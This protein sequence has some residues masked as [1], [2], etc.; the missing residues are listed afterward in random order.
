[1][2]S[3]TALKETGGGEPSRSVSNLALRT[4]TAL[5]G[6]PILVA[7]IWWGE[8]GVFLLVSAF[9]ILGVRE[10]YGLPSLTPR[11]EACGGGA[12]RSAG[13]WPAGRLPSLTPRN[14]ACGGGASRSPGSWPAGRLAPNDATKL[15]ALLGV[16][17]AFA[18]VVAA[19][20]T[21]A[22]WE[23]LAASVGVLLGGAFLALLWVIAYYQDRGWGA[24]AYLVGGPLYVG[25]LLSHA[26]ALRGL[27]DGGALGRD[28]LLFAIAT[29][30]ATDTG[31]FLVG[32]SLGR[33]RMAP[34]VSPGKT[35][36]GALGGM[37]AAIAAATILGRVLTLGL[38]LWQPALLGAAVGVSSQLGDLLESRLK[39]ISQVK[40]AGSI[41][42]GHGGV[43]DRLD[44]LL[45]S[46]STVYYAV[47]GVLER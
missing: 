14:E 39:R 44:S 32:R 1:M 7:A 27:D 47:V 21:G 41:I 22:A 13:S 33:H 12:S 42:P 3:L 18:F 19:Q 6:I 45:L 29:T 38:P 36:E 31:A 37:V 23:F 26:V 30:F 2:S 11:N 24:A 20:A 5:V 15:P 9:V 35:W 25:F 4:F 10:M 43:L 8:T 17:W 34:N 28:W 16:A 46:L 40:D